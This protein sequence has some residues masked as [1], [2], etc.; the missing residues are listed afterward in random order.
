MKKK[1][2]KV[3]EKKEKEEKLVLIIKRMDIARET[4]LGRQKLFSQDNIEIPLIAVKETEEETSEKISLR[5]IR[6]YVNLNFRK[7]LMEIEARSKKV[8]YQKGFLHS[9]LGFPVKKKVIR[10]GETKNLV[11]NHLR[12]T[13][14][15]PKNIGVVALAFYLK[16]F[17]EVFFGI[18]KELSYEE[19]ADV[20]QTK[21][22]NKE[23]KKELIEFFDSLSKQIYEGE[24]TLDYKKTYELAEKTVKTLLEGKEK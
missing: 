2:K 22:I 15:F 10:S 18:D 4:P 1:V 20:L 7:E 24:V 11:L 19:F 9:L 14:P 16:E 6:N 12:S 23:L 13:K 17:L 21:P 5:S 3:P 8:V